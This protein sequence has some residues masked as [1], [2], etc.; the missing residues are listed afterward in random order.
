MQSRDARPRRPRAPT[1]TP[2]F[3]CSFRYNGKVTI[4]GSAYVTFCLPPRP[5][6]CF[7]NRPLVDFVSG[8]IVARFDF[9][10]PA[11]AQ[12]NLTKMPYRCVCVR[13]WQGGGIRWLFAGTDRYSSSWPPW[14]TPGSPL[15]M[16]LLSGAFR[17][18]FGGSRE[19]LWQRNRGPATIAAPTPRPSTRSPADRSTEP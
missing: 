12:L 18:E 3:A 4:V 11:T 6:I 19:L 8:D 2:N 15:G 14:M 13:Q 7:A 5:E 9:L 1:S 16:R 10:A 17:R